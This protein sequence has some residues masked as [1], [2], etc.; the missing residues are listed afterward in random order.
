M[1]KPT[2]ANLATVKAGVAAAA[3]IV[4]IGGVAVATAGGERPTDGTPPELPTVA[5]SP[6]PGDPGKDPSGV[7]NGPKATDKP[8]PGDNGKNENNPSPTPSLEG[9]CHAYTAGAGAE[10]GKRLDNP[11]F[12]YLILS[13]GAEDKV[14]GYCADLLATK[15]GGPKPPAGKPTTHPNRPGEQGPGDKPKDN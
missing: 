4:A 15:P 14:D 11:A 7:P 12:S 1:L 2:L 10:H 13:A 9:L 6:S 8:A 5:A 3:V